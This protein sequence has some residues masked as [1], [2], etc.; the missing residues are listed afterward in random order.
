MN[1]KEN[2]EALVVVSKDIGIE[3]NVDKTWY[4]VMS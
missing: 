1:C 4:M 2:T 3:V